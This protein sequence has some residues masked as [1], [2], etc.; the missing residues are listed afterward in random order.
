MPLK[1]EIKK[2][3]VFIQTDTGSIVPFPQLQKAEIKKSSQQVKHD[4]QTWQS[5]DG[6][7]TPPYPPDSFLMLYE[8]NPIF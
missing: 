5:V 7:M 8:S 4:E 1:K 2:G 6:I 3:K